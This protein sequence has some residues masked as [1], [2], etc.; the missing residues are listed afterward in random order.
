MFTPIVMATLTL[1]RCGREF[2]EK[3]IAAGM[4]AVRINSAHVTPLQLKEM[5]A[6][7][8]EISPD[9]IILTDTKGAE[10]RTSYSAYP[11]V[12]TEGESIKFAYEP[13]KESSSECVRINAPEVEQHI[14]V[15]QRMLID[16]GEVELEV[17]E[18]AEDYFFAVALRDGKIESRK[19]VSFPGVDL[20]H[21]PSVTDRDRE[22]IIA[23]R[24]AGVDM[25]AHSFVRN[26]NDVKAVKDLLKGST[27]RLYAKIECKSALHNLDEIMNA[28]DGILFARGDLGAAIPL[29]QLPIVQ[30]RVLSRCR[31]KGCKVILSTQ[32]LQSMLEHPTPTRAEVNDIFLGV[33]EGASMFL[34]C[35]ET[36]Q[37]RYP[38]EAVNILHRTLFESVSFFTAE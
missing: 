16:D 8:K 14:T 4:S 25:I 3:M 21:L 15:G 10:V 6:Q 36:A 19:T 37:G 32:L 11:V 35:G 9:L 13:G 26:A 2:V 18:I 12:I 33:A 24:E 27:V 30:Y 7:L 23:A 29:S 5:V 1:D 22:A 31:E 20:M 17:K 28:S 38:V 34:L